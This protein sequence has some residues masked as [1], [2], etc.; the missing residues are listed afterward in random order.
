MQLRRFVGLVDLGILT[1]VVVAL[2]LPDREMYAA[3]VFK[4]DDAK[5]FAL[6]LAEARTIARP[7]DGKSIE[8]LARELGDAGMKDWAI[9]SAIAGS[10]HA[11][12]SPTRWHALLAA[13]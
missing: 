6:A 3:N 2:V 5:Q 7:D 4:G 10:D 1:V 9:E 8:L 13:S 12:Q 11:K